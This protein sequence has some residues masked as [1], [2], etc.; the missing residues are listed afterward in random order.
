VASSWVEAGP[1]MAAGRTWLGINHPTITPPEKAPPTIKIE[2]TAI[3][4]I[5]VVLDSINAPIYKPV[6]MHNS[7][8]RY[9]V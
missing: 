8:Q 3:K 2:I 6:D 1:N 9:H 4:M 5:L 7:N